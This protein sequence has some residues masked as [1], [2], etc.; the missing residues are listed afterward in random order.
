MGQLVVRGHVLTVDDDR[1]VLA[2]GAVY[3]NDGRIEAVSD[4][5]AA[6]PAGY[7]GVPRLRVD[8]V[9]PGLIDLHNHLAYN[10][11]PLWLAR[12][13]PYGTRYQWPRAASYGPDV[14]NPAQALGIAAPAAALRFAEVKAVVGGVTAIQGSPPVTRT[15]PGWMLRNVEKEEFGHGQ[16]I[17][18]SVLVATGQQLDATREAPR[19][20]QGVHLPPRRGH[21]PGTA[22]RVRT[23][24]RPRL[25]AGRL[26]RDPFDRARRRRLPRAGR[27]RAAARSC[28]RRSRTS[29]CTAAQR[30]LSSARKHGLRVCF[31]SDWTPSGTRNVLGEL[32][33]AAT[34]EPHGARQRV[35]TR[36]ARRDG[37]CEPGRDPGSAVGRARR[38][39]RRGRARRPRV[40]HRG[41]RRSVEDGAG[42]DGTQRAARRRRRPAGVRQP[43]VARARR[44][45]EPGVDHGR[46]HP[47]RDRHG[48][49]RGVASGGSRGPRGSDEVVEGRA[50]GTGS[51]LG[52]SR[53]G[54]AQG[55]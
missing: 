53:R 27:A 3:V 42:R 48:P 38:P 41:A 49:P 34:V 54:C 26:D 43:F 37:D 18:Q 6:P 22:C 31:G 19:R 13:E 12:P 21:R 9:T 35:R 30:T 7:K 25:R 55:S 23:A 51:S 29:G 2:D 32:K 14:S 44:G 50:R 1:R 16:S 8:V 28:G 45:A 11:L 17:F 40:L 20:W 36:R 47:A 10:T 24:R 5:S 4:A 46:R 33:V 52:R 39:T 15:F